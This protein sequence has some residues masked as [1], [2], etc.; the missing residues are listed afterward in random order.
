MAIVRASQILPTSLNE[1][2]ARWYDTS[3]WPRWVDGLSEIVSVDGDWPHAEARVTWQSN[4]SGRGRVVERV[5]EYDPQA[6]QT[7][8]I[9]DDSISGRQSV[10]FAPVAGGAE[11]ILGLEY[12]LRR[13]SP[14]TPLVDPLFIRPAIKRSLQATLVRFGAELRPAR[15]ADVG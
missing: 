8:E 6:G 12:R 9:Q 7:L 2:Q 14:L 4:P 5:L 11:L 13:R 3:R 10:A 15:R 1:V